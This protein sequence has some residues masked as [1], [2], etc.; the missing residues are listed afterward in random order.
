MASVER[1]REL[2]GAEAAEAVVRLAVQPGHEVPDAQLLDEVRLLVHSGA[3]FRKSRN[4]GGFR[5]LANPGIKE[6]SKI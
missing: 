2:E 5:N 6:D 3:T 1:I 4:L